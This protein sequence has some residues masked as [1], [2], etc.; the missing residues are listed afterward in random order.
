[1]KK[2]L[3]SLTLLFATSIIAHAQWTTTGTTTSTTNSVGIS[4][5]APISR[6]QVNSTVNKFSVGGGFLSGTELWHLVRW[7]QCR[8]YHDHIIYGLDYRRRRLS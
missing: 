4:T 5:T 6:F 1:M 7:V 2:T 3:L 8:P